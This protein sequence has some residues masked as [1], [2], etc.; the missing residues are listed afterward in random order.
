MKMVDKLTITEDKIKLSISNQTNFKTI[1][2]LLEIEECSEL[3]ID[4]PS[5]GE[6]GGLDCSE[7]GMAVSTTVS[8]SVS[9]P[10]NPFALG[11]GFGVRQLV[12]GYGRCLLCLAKVLFLF[13]PDGE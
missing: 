6:V 3:Q 7:T 2:I 8:M 10:F 11:P 12:A 9:E 5:V 1:D 4:N 13:L